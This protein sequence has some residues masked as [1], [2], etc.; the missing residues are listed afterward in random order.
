V[1]PPQD[2]PVGFR[3]SAW[4]GADS[5]IVEAERRNGILHLRLFDKI[6]PPSWRPLS[7]ARR[8]W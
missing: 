3:N 8:H 6:S 4:H 7:C 1:H 5:F 2:L